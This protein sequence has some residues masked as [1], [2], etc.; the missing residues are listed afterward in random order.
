MT[1]DLAWKMG[2]DMI[3]VPLPPKKGAK[4]TNVFGQI[5]HVRA[6]VDYQKGPPDK[7]WYFVVFR[8]WS[9]RKKRWSYSIEDCY[10]LELGLLKPVT[11]KKK[12]V[13]V[14]FETGPAVVGA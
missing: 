9:V 1:T 8:S 5:H 2:V 4:Y 6:I 13:Q 14:H 10:A 3:D 11:R 12:T 7:R